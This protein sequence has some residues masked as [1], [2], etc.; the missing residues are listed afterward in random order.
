MGGPGTELWDVMLPGGPVGL[1]SCSSEAA[2]AQ[3]HR[4]MNILENDGKFTDLFT[5]KQGTALHGCS[6]FL[7]IQNCYVLVPAIGLPSTAA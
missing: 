7:R 3:A 2:E 6:C 5:G 4:H 1:L